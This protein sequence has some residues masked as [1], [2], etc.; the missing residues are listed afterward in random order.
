MTP[1]MKVS[2]LIESAL[3]VNDL[4]AAEQFYTEVL[5]LTPY[6]RL[7]G[8]HVFLRCGQRMVLLFNPEATAISAGGANDAPAHGATE[9]G[10]LAFAVPQSEIGLWKQ[11]LAKHGVKIEKEVHWERCRSHYFRDPSHNSVEITSP[12]LWRVP[13]ESILPLQGQSYAGDGK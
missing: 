4:S 12:L 8:R 5:G 13:G 11:H 3:Y 2:E 1:S 6:S 7:E 9:P 10:H